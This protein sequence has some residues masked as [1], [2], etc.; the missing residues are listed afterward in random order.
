MNSFQ[1]LGRYSTFCLGQTE[2]LQ[3]NNVEGPLACAGLDRCAW[4]Q[5]AAQQCAVCCGG[6]RS[7]GE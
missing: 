1:G 6:G 7:I 2:Q 4:Q 5:H 3:G